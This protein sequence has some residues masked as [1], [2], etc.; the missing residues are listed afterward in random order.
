V[1]ES[2]KEGRGSKRANA[3]DDNDDYLFNA[4]TTISFFIVCMF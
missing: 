2:S 1:V 4:K 3:N